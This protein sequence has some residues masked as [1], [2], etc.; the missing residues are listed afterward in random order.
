MLI[1]STLGISLFLQVHRRSTFITIPSAKND[2]RAL[3]RMALKLYLKHTSVKK[4]VTYSFSSLCN[5]M[6]CKNNITTLKYWCQRHLT[7]K[8][9]LTSPKSFTSRILQEWAQSML[10]CNTESLLNKVPITDLFW[11][12]LLHAIHENQAFQIYHLQWT[13]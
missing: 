7:K 2:R 6:W 11:P 9:L 10:I 8:S 13:Y 5:E 3:K 12:C 4:K 1:T